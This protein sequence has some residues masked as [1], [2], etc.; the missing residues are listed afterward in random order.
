[1]A[2]YSVAGSGIIT[3]PGLGRQQERK[4]KYQQ[5][6]E[7]FNVKNLPVDWLSLPYPEGFRAEQKKG[8]TA[9]FLTVEGVP[10]KCVYTDQDFVAYFLEEHPQAEDWLAKVEF[11]LLLPIPCVVRRDIIITTVVPVGLTKHRPGS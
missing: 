6:G 9:F 3:K 2:T 5:T 10:E 11:F 8:W 7:K 1:M 4:P